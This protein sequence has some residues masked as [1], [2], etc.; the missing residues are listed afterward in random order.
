MA[1]EA[2][3]SRDEDEKAKGQCS[4]NTHQEVPRWET[5]IREPGSAPERHSWD[6]G[7]ANHMFV[8]PL[9]LDEPESCQ[10]A[11]PRI[12]PPHY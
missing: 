12:S 8:L 3:K 2:E 5:T 11:G 6:F 10:D 1:E 7:A 4:L 9:R